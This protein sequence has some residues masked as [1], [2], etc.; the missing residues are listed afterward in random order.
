MINNRLMERTILIIRE[1]IK[2]VNEYFK[3]DKV[4]K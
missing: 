3:K 2:D 4:C 1:Q